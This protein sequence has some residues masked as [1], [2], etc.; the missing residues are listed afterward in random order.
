MVQMVQSMK[1]KNFV[2]LL[3][4]NY[5][6]VRAQYPQE[7]RRKW[8]LRVLQGF[9]SPQALDFT[10]ASACKHEFTQDSDPLD[11][12]VEGQQLGVLL[13]TDYSDEAAWQAFC[14]KL[15]DAEEEIRDAPTHTND[16]HPDS[17]LT[18]DANIEESAEQEDEESESES[19]TDAALLIKAIDPASQDL[20]EMFYHV[21][22]LTALR[23]LNDVDIRPSPIPPPGTKRIQPPNR[24]I[25]QNGWQEIYTG[26]NIWIYDVHSN[27]DQCARLVSQQGDMYGTATADSWRARVTHICE[28]Q[29]NMSCLGMKI[30]FG[31]LDRWDFNERYRNLQEAALLHSADPPSSGN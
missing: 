20:R 1:D 29:F 8:H 19:S 24:L 21:S 22:N 16:T 28:L 23:L 26:L 27:R 10:P 5:A 11:E 25:D 14:S 31:G 2:Q 3:T 12:L 17:M 13:R 30:D 9:W 4:I 18:D 7:G 6:H 15:R